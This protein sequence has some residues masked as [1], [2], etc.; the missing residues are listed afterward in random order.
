M[1]LQPEDLLDENGK[2]DHNKVRSISNRGN[3]DLPAV[4][5]ETCARWRREAIGAPS[6]KAVAADRTHA[7]DTIRRHISG[8]C[9]CQNDAP[10]LVYDRTYQESAAGSSGEWV[11]RD[12]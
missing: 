9:T 10:P 8:E 5:D 12:E 1:S 2:V 7:E 6:A 3:S 11:I 4:S